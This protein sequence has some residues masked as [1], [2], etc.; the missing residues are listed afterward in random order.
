MT[1]Y[2][3]YIRTSNKQ[4][5]FT[6]VMIKGTNIEVNHRGDLIIKDK[7]KVVAAF[8]SG[9]WIRMKEREKDA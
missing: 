9:D 1:L 3:I 4:T 2:D 7:A 5:P 6:I 8:S